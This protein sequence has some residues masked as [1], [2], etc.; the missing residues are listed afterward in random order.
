MEDTLPLWLRAQRELRSLLGN[1]ENRQTRS[2]HEDGDVFDSVAEKTHFR[3][4]RVNNAITVNPSAAIVGV[5]F[6]T[7]PR[8]R[9]NTSGSESL[10]ESEKLSWV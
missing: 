8:K 6:R 7:E 5:L 1:R 4:S 9:V 10:L 2:G 3:T